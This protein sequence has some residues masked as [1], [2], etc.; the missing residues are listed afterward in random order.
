MA[1]AGR[2]WSNGRT[3]LIHAEFAGETSSAIAVASPLRDN[4]SVMEDV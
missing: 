4:L 2:R 1:N 3:I